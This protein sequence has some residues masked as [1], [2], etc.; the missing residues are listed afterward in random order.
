VGFLSSDALAIGAATL[1]F[2]GLLEMQRALATARKQ[3]RVGTLVTRDSMLP[4]EMINKIT[5][6]SR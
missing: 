6:I 1:K 4:Q 3:C 2:D 5:K